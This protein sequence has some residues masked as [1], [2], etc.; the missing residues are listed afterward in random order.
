VAERE[1]GSAAGGPVGRGSGVRHGPTGPHGA[2]LGPSSEQPLD[3]GGVGGGPRRGNRN[4][5]R[6]W[7]AGWLPIPGLPGARRRA[8]RERPRSGLGGGQQPTPWCPRGDS[9]HAH[10]AA[11][12][13]AAAP[14]A[15]VQ[16]G[17]GAAGPVAL[18][19]T[20]AVKEAR[21]DRPAT[22]DGQ[23]GSVARFPAHGW[24]RRRRETSA[25]PG[26]GT[27]VRVDSP[28]TWTEARRGQRQR[29]RGQRTTKPW[30]GSVLR[31]P[32]SGGLPITPA[33]GAW[34]AVGSGSV[35]RP[36]SARG[37]E[38]GEGRPGSGVP[39]G[40]RAQPETPPGGLLRGAGS[41]QRQVHRTQLQSGHDELTAALERP[42]GSARDSG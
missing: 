33:R 32:T 4:A 25:G 34:P 2:A 20:H 23:S 35:R 7:S 9:V 22:D 6:T 15:M 24:G 10:T 26:C 40:F 17:P 14:R 11:R 18:R 36:E 19:R 29:R 37:S 16:S 8:D 21:G 30:R 42:S 39:V 38:L 31:T 13:L 1:K 41:A 27:A 12:R 3:Y 28:M 5:R